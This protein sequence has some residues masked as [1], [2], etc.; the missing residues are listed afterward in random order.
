[1]NHMRNLI[2]L[3][4][5]TMVLALLLAGCSDDSGD[6]DDNPQATGGIGAAATGGAATGGAGATGTGGGGATGTG[7]A[8]TGGVS[9]G[10]EA[11]CDNVVACGGDI[12]GTWTVSDSCVSLGGE[13]DVSLQGLGCAIGTVTATTIEVSGTWTA[14]ADGTYT[15]NLTWT[16]TETIGLS[17]DCLNVSGTTT[18][19]DRVGSPMVGLGYHQGLNYNSLDCVDDPATGGCTCTGVI[20]QVQNAVGG[21]YTVD[22]N[23]VTTSEGMVFSFCVAGTELTMTPAKWATNTTTTT[24]GTVVLQK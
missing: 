13:L 24:T 6:S 23:T 15:D 19:C 3:S 4:T 14:N 20:E 12:V 18:T 1:M 17:P 11:S 7:G 5:N 9:G 10:T 2:A 21:T 22:A 16:G 8:A